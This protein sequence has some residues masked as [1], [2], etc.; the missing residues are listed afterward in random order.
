MRFHPLELMIESGLS[1][2]SFIGASFIGADAKVLSIASICIAFYNLFIHSNL[3][4]TYG[5]MRYIFVSPVFHRWH[6]SDSRESA[7]KNF[8]SM[9]SFLDLLLGSFYMP[10]DK[11]PET[12]GII[13]GEK[14]KQPKSFIGQTLYPFR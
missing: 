2:L 7:N 10:L 4:F 12:T 3:R 5:P 14:S 13:A 1:V 8:A 9:F 6:H 11:M